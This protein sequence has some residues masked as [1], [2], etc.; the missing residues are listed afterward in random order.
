LTRFPPSCYPPAVSPAELGVRMT[1]SLP[2][3]RVAVLALL[4]ATLAAAAQQETRIPRIGF[5]APTAPSPMTEGFRRGLRDLGYVQ[6]QNIVILGD[7]V[8]TLHRARIVELAGKTRVPA[9][10]GI[11][12]AA[13]AIPPAVLARADEVIE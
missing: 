7:P 9:M 13:E 11:R 12:E 3:V 1:L 5:L 2:V 8:F 10:Y 4:A 6:G